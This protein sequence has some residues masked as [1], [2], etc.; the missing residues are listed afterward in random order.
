MTMEWAPFT[1]ALDYWKLGADPDGAEEQAENDYQARYLRLVEGLRGTRLIE[2][3]LTAVDGEAFAEA[4]QRFDD[5]LFAQDWAATEETLGREPTVE[6]LPRSAQQRRHDALI[7]MAHA[8]CGSSPEDRRPEPLVSVLVDLDTLE[9]AASDMTCELGSG[10]VI[11]PGQLAPLLGRAFIERIV[12][13]GPA[14]RLVEI[15]EQRTF[16]GAARRAVQVLQR[17]CQHPGCRVPAHRCELDHKVPY[18][19]GGR[20][21]LDNAQLLCP[22]HNRW[23][24]DRLPGQLPQ[25]RG[26]P[27]P[28]GEVA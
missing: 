22:A 8:A 6:E 28:E 7:C 18:S 2:G 9:G 1:Q 26:E 12:Y 5:E 3:E 17:H 27:P 16:T 14:R 25:P 19:Q 13:H 10:Q 24:G 11:T 4:L 15:G 20:T 21:A 23:K